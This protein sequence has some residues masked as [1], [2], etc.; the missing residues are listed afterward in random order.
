MRYDPY[1][2]KRAAL[3]S[4]HRSGVDDDK[5]AEAIA[6]AIADALEDY[7]NQQEPTRV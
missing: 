3:K 6:K 2:V 1:S 4:L 7:V 5:L